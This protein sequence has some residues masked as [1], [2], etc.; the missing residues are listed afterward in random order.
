MVESMHVSDNVHSNE[1]I[2]YKQR[3]NAYGKEERSATAECEDGLL[4]E[5][6]TEE[7]EE[8]AQRSA[9]PAPK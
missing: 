3:Q 5:I 8:V 2:G 7:V 9:Q 4:L 6:S 1:R